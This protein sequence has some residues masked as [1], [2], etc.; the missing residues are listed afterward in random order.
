MNNCFALFFFRGTNPRT[1]GI[2]SLQPSP[3]L[4]TQPQWAYAERVAPV[5]SFS[6]PLQP[7]PMRPA[8]GLHRA[9][10]TRELFLGHLLQ[11]SPMRPAVG[12]RRTYRT[13]ELFLGPPLLPSPMRPA[14]GLRR[15]FRPRELF[16][17]TNFIPRRP[18]TTDR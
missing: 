12:L 13:R 7:S 15:T 3:L 4:A 2:T 5:I 10:R 6:V 14:V 18:F 17:G 9:C 1:L 8:V 11:L 16:L